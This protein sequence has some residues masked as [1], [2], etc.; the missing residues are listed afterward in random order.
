MAATTPPPDRLISRTEVARAV[1]VQPAAVSNWARRHESFPTAQK[2]H[3]RYGYIPSE[4]ARWLDARTIPESARR[5]DE[6]ADA[7]FG[8]RFRTALGP[9]L[10]DTRPRA[11]NM[12]GA[13]PRIRAENSAAAHEWK[14]GLWRLSE[15]SRG[16][17]DSPTYLHVMSAILWLRQ[18][19]EDEW[20]AIIDC[21]PAQVYQ[22]LHY[23]WHKAAREER[24]DHALPTIDPN[25]WEPQ[26]LH[27]AAHLVNRVVET[28]SSGSRAREGL[29]TAAAFDIM[30]NTFHRSRKEGM[31]EYQVPRG[32][33]EVMIGITDPKSTDRVYD[34]W[35]GLGQLLIAA[36]EHATG[37]ARSIKRTLKGN[38]P[39]MYSWQ[40]G[41]LNA[42]IHGLDIDLGATPVNSLH[43][44]CREKFDVVVTNPPF[45]LKFEED[46]R[47]G[48][49]PRWR[50]GIPPAN[51]A[52]FAWL[53]LAASS[54]NSQGRAAIVMPSSAAFTQSLRE[55]AI[56][57]AMIEAG[58]IQSIIALPSRLF[59]DTSIPVTLWVVGPPSP[60]HCRTVLLVDASAAGV[61][62]DRSQHIL[63]SH[64]IE[65]IVNTYRT[66]RGASGIPVTDTDVHS[67]A[68]SISEI[69]DNAF[70]LDPRRYVAVSSFRTDI[71]WGSEIRRR[72]RALAEH[73][74]RAVIADSAFDE[75]LDRL[76]K[77]TR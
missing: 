43:N 52:N 65:A 76:G 22:R 15:A 25:P 42:A 40:L 6:P 77:W 41:I 12:T 53:Q 4:I 27:R 68:V 20:T 3:G 30:L 18:A 37:D 46:I 54:L 47:H 16:S 39:G 50:F 60:D 57:R 13:Q 70:N 56:R 58:V 69:Q 24:L 75:I 73:D 33:V 74:S 72:R 23:A 21:P 38:T 67:R 9:A 66:H 63:R 10:V 14:N 62:G 45:N 61:A 35:C 2:Q 19:R 5:P 11:R 8:R 29:T 17:L 32:L 64:A 48:D 34:P 36:A 51:N 7:T 44:P 1:G 28:P 49:D 59:R 31:G 55:S 71:N 26:I